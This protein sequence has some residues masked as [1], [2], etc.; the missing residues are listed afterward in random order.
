MKEKTV[1]MKSKITKARQ[2]KTKQ[3]TINQVQIIIQVFKAKQQRYH[4]GNQALQ[5]ILQYKV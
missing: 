2:M 1:K 3:V 5:Q 4:L